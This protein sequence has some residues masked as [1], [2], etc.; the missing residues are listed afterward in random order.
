MLAAD[1][2]RGERCGRQGPIG[3]EVRLYWMVPDLIFPGGLHRQRVNN[4]MLS[5]GEND[6]DFGQLSDSGL[7][8][9]CFDLLSR[10]G[11]HSLEWR[12]G[13]A[14]KGRDIEGLLPVSNNLVGPY[15]ERWFFECKRFSK[16]V[17]PAEL[18]S[19]IAWADAERPQHLV[20]F[21]SSYLSTA[22]RDWVE[23][24]RLQKS[25]RIHVVEGKSLRR[26]LLGFPEIVQIYFGTEVNQLVRDLKRQWM[27]HDLLPGPEALHVLSG[28]LPAKLLSSSDY[29]FLWCCLYL[30]SSE[31]D[32]WC[33][34]NVPFSF[35]SLFPLLK[36]AT[37]CEN[38]VIW[39]QA[40][41][42]AICEAAGFLNHSDKYSRFVSGKLRLEEGG[43]VRSGLYTF[44]AGKD[45]E[46]IEVLVE[47]TSDF[48]ARIRY[49][50]QNAEVEIESVG[51]AFRGMFFGTQAPSNSE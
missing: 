28:K 6:I 24:Q 41:S 32:D 34:D 3:G 43:R 37:T 18:N 44:V 49:I 33:E 11:F 51:D 7:E 36:E 29:A 39:G 25:Y 16:G 10:L 9:C 8:E 48:P 50:A 17:P 47:A 23:K 26:L 42:R 5:I 30:H 1:G 45:G 27:L 35:D 46:G 2:L 19:K 40:G 12:Q 20:F 15:Q 31:V 14:D 4:L 38:S 21:I 22:A 13:G